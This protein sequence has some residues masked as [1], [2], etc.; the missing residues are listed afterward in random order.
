MPDGKERKEKVG[1]KIKNSLGFSVDKERLLFHMR[2][3][4][5]REQRERYGNV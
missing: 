2:R 4:N 1:G 3:W 5:A